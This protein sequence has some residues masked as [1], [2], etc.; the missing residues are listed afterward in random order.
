MDL[1]TSFGYWV[2]RRRKALDLTQADLARRVGCAEVTIQK[3]EA[4]ERRPSRQ[5]VELLAEH[6]R[7]PPADR[8][9]FLQRARGELA[10]EQLPAST[11]DGRHMAKP[12]ALA[13]ID[14]SAERPPVGTVTFLFTDIAGSTQLWEQHPQ[15]MS[16]ALAR[17]D[18]L[19]R[20][21]IAAHGGVIVKTT[22]DGAHAAFATAPDALA[23][24]LAIGRALQAEQW[25]ALGALRVRMALHSGVAE[26]RD[27]DY[28]GPALN[29]VARLLAAGHGGQTL[30]SAAA[31][32]LARDH[33]PSDVA[34]RDLGEH[35]LKDLSR[36]EHIFQLIAPDLPTDFPPLR[37]L[38]RR[39][40]NLPA[41]PTALIGREHELAAI[42]KNL[43]RAD[44]RLL[45][46][47]GPG[48]IGKTRLA[49]QA[50][51]AAVDD[52]AHGVYV[53]N[54]API[55]DPALVVPTIAQ[56]LGV[57]ERGSRP[58][59]ESLKAELHDKDM[60]LL[61][62]NFEQVL[63]AAA[64]LA[65]LLAGCPKL[66]LLITSREVLHLYGEHEFGV[67]PLALPDRAQ[68][69][70]LSR[71]T[72]YDAVRLFIERARAVKA[73]FAVTNASAPAVAEIC[74]RLDGLP[75]AIELAAARVKL[76]SPQALLSRL[77]HRLALLTGGPRDLP[78][79]HQTIRGAIDWSYHL[80]DA[81]EQMLFAR[82]GVFAS[83]WTLEAAETIC[84]GDGLAADAILDVLTQLVNKSLVVVER[85]QGE[86]TRYRLLETIRQY[87]WE[88]L[89]ESG[90]GDSV[91]DRHLNYFTALAEHADP[92][93]P[94]PKQITWLN[95]L[96]AELDNL[97]AALQW[98]LQKDVA[99]GLRMAAALRGFWEI[100]GFAGDGRD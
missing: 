38:E 52:F 55:S 91:R 6:L 64:Q 68:L 86:E 87:A 59:L 28:F 71:L 60:L 10:S 36:P 26:M 88:R 46:L 4:D 40:T 22:G 53:V 79:R 30:L 84:A 66:K 41:Q 49:L 12:L 23:A 77:E 31:W 47:T 24:A 81:A 11:P 44:V 92:E 50:A 54:L 99:A 27:G 98:S 95:R 85:E 97:R 100:R 51:A 57:N 3:I 70:P 18:A 13:S 82:L 1:P 62:D 67:P 58:L 33:L 48:G 29:R 45:T 35:R 20:Q 37:T 2:R 7:I 32:E 80:L 69:P 72:Q 76:F 89:V 5:I 94:G 21:Q 8:A 17:H 39:R 74:Y 25:G 34:L 93:L 96:E 75:L 73:D 63:T 16:A 78:A 42:R 65:E 83:G 19:L 90:E 9:T 14:A 56:T 15:A 43:G 61:L